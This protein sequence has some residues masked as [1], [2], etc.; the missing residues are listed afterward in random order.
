MSERPSQRMDDRE[1]GFRIS[2]NFAEGQGFQKRNRIEQVFDPGSTI[3]YD[4]N[5]R[6]MSSEVRSEVQNITGKLS[7]TMR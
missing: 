1:G 5:E 7:N 2:D 6:V 3:Q 4:D